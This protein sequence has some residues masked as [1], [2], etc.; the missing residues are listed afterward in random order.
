M[1][2]P[3]G[4]ADSLPGFGNTRSAKGKTELSSAAHGEQIHS[5]KIERL[6]YER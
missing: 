6:S 2:I 1:K 5:N 3:V 4:I